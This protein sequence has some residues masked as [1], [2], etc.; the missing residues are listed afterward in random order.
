MVVGVVLVAMGTS[1]PVLVLVPVPVIAV[2][3]AVAVRC[4]RGRETGM[5]ERYIPASLL[6]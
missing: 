2:I 3:A 6:R 1:F 5:S 4:G